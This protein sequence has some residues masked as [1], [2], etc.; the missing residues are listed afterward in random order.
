M[1]SGNAQLHFIHGQISRR[2]GMLDEAK[3]ALLQASA[4]DCGPWRATELQNSIIKK[5]AKE[6]QILLFDFAKVVEDDFGKNTTF[7]DEIHPQNLYY[8]KGMAQ[9]GL[10]IKSIL[11]L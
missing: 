5:V 9:L 8:D 7:F 10:V 1:Y 4:Y 11:K 3:N 6:H 2:L